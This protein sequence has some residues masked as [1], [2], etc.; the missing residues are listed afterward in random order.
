MRRNASY[1]FLGNFA[2]KGLGLGRE[3]LTAALFGTGALVAAFRIGL[4]GT[5]IPI[6]FL[7]SDALNSVYIPLHK[8]F[9]RRSENGA[10]LFVWTS[11]A[12]LL[13]VA[14][15]IGT[16]LW[17]GAS[18]WVHALA[19]G[20]RPTVRAV[21]GSVLRILSIGVPLYLLSAF[22]VF[23]GMANDDFLPMSVR[24]SI[25]NV[26]LIIGIASAYL[27]SSPDLFAWGF[28]LSY[29][30]FF[31]WAL[32]REFTAGLLRFPSAFDARAV[33]RVLMRI[34]RTLRPL[35][36]LPVFLQGNIVVER[37]VA[38]FISV[39]CVSAL[40]YARFV[41]ESML[42]MIAVPVSY[43]G[44]TEWSGLSLRDMRQRLSKVIAFSL[45][46]G[47]PISAF[48][49]AN[50][51]LAVKILYARGAF[52]ER[53]VQ[54]TAHIL[55]G[56]AYGLWAQVLGYILIKALSAQR[57]NGKVLYIMAASLFCNALFDILLYRNFGARTLGLGNS[58]YGIGIL[59]GTLTALKL[60]PAFIR[61]GS[62]LLIGGAGYC[63]LMA[64]YSS[65]P[66]TIWGHAVEVG[67][68]TMAFWAA[69]ILAQGKLRRFVLQILFRFGGGGKG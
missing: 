37:M 63:A 49:L 22:L 55:S 19:P 57:Q 3:I 58:L 36:L 13:V 67:L 11:G 7:T 38:S 64:I 45:V 52:T 44:L 5:L 56:I 30:A 39:S 4:A 17:T 8:H 46:V 47:I 40:D 53:S 66:H 42:A 15:T 43:A 28:T 61:E 25:Q 32:Q 31:F 50:A 24:A 6:N 65:H 16:V 68:L 35:L 27:F 69:W 1:V 41:S 34:W 21:A 26:G 33:K 60:W 9:A 2:S 20:L 18:I 12:A 23:V 14:L 54:V 51:S 62:S 59:T 29:L 48:L 10:R